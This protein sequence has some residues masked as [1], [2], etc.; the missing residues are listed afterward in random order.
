M[1]RNY[2]EVKRYNSLDESRLLMPTN[3]LDDFMEDYTIYSLNR[4]WIN[5]FQL[6]KSFIRS[7]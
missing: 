4:P 6:W 5:R 7:K 2:K 3:L 1:E